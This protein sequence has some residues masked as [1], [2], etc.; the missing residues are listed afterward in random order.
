MLIVVALFYVVNNES[1]NLDKYLPLLI[2]PHLFHILCI[3]IDSGL[4]RRDIITGYAT[5]LR[6]LDEVT[7]LDGI[8]S[9]ALKPVL[10]LFYGE[11]N[12]AAIKRFLTEGIAKKSTKQQGNVPIYDLL[13][14]S[15]DLADADVLDKR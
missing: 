15:I 10:G 11:S 6:G 13:M 7:P 1:S 12:S 9:I 2:Y 14:R 4:T 8:K 3:F 5:F